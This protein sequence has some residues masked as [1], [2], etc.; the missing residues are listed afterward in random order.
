VSIAIDLNGVGA[1]QSR[2]RLRL[3]QRHA[4]F[5]LVWKP[6]IIGIQEGD[7]FSSRQAQPVVPSRAPL[8]IGLPDI[9]NARRE[10]LNDVGCSVRRAIVHQ[11]YAYSPRNGVHHAV[12]IAEQQLY[13]IPIVEDRHENK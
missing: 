6:Q 7:I 10:L 5:N 13:S 9:A 12:Q 8:G 1:D 4:S 2:L 11:K 3:Q